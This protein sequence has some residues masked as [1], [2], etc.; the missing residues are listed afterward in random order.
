M[1]DRLSARR[2][3]DNASRGAVR[4]ELSRSDSGP[5][6]GRTAVTVTIFR[7]LRVGCALAAA[8]CGG[9]ATCPNGSAG[10]AA[11]VGRLEG[12]L[13]RASSGLVCFGAGPSIVTEDGRIVLPV[14]VGDAEAAARLAHL[15]EHLAFE[16]PPPGA[17]CVQAWVRQ[18]ARAYAVELRERARLGVLEPVVR[19]PFQDAESEASI[20]D[21]LLA[22]PQGHGPIGPLV[23]DYRRRC[24]RPEIAPE[25]Q[26]SKRSP[27]WALSTSTRPPWTSPTMTLASTLPPL[28]S[29]MSSPTWVRVPP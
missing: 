12:L 3:R 14:D 25:A 13:Q 6:E 28:T 22:H 21:W 5:G 16:R 29:P 7:W 20:A 4:A 10:D 18:E 17:G 1:G 23:A 27:R 8:A 19:Y 26:G 11:R 9:T 2:L 15:L 24:A